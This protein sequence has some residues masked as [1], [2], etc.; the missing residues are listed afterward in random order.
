MEFLGVIVLVIELL[1][2]FAPVSLSI[3]PA[4]GPHAVTR[5]RAP[6][7][8][9]EGGMIPLGG[10]VEEQRS[11]SLALETRGRSQAGEVRQ[12]WIQIN[13]FGQARAGLAGGLEAPAR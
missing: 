10:Q 9:R 2:L 6:L 12:R 3:A 5:R 7:D 1:P 8:L 11:Q 13:Q 4:L